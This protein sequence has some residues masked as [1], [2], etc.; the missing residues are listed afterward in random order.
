MSFARRGS[1][2][3]GAGMGLPNRQC[4]SPGI[5]SLGARLFRVVSRTHTERAMASSCCVRGRFPSPVENTVMPVYCIGSIRLADVP[6]AHAPWRARIRHLRPTIVIIGLLSIG[7]AA[8]QEAEE[9]VSAQASTP[10]IGPGRNGKVCEYEDVTGSRMRKRVCYTP[11]QWEA[12]ERAAKE[13][14]RELDG[15]PIGRNGEGG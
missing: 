9:A 13:L 6:A 11:A 5:E 8:A 1:H 15:K 4:R 10:V 2:A 7:Q 12:R 14:V 3:V